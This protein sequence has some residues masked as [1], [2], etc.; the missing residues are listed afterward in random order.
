MMNKRKNS[1]IF[2]AVIIIA[3][4]IFTSNSL[5]ALTIDKDSVNKD[6]SPNPSD[7]VMPKYPGGESAMN[8]FISDNLIY[9]SNAQRADIQGRVVIRFVV[10]KTG[11]LKDIN[12][13]RGLYPS[14]DAEAKRVIGLMP[15]WEP[16]KKDGEN[17]DIYFTIPIHFR[18]RDNPNKKLQTTVY[19]VDDEGMNAREFNSMY[20]EKDLIG[21]MEILRN[22]IFS[23][24]KTLKRY[25]DKYVDCNIFEI[26]M[27]PASLQLDSPE[28]LSGKVT[29]NPDVAPSFPGGEKEM[30]KF[31][32]KKLKTPTY[33][34]KGRVGERIVAGFIVRRSGEITDLYIVEGAEPTCN[35]E[36]IR[37][38]EAMPK[39]V[40]GK[41]DGE[42]KDCLVYIPIS[43][44]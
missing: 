7:E 1:V 34:K 41:V 32:K 38:I 8:G 2:I 9:P 4:T 40:P 37:L 33:A 28:L 30:N 12:V 35:A 10:T 27:K 13:I 20:E 15:K 23:D 43:F 42:N 29:A 16:G 18:M 22:G 39:W 19:L 6:L 25:G 21:K 17:A 14:C 11:E 3:S 26:S 36:V 24:S 44:K 31:I 5:R